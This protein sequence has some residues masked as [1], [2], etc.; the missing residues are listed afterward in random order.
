ML[1]FQYDLIGETD[2]Q[3]DRDPKKR[4]AKIISELDVNGDKK[5]NKQ[6]FITG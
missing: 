4:A 6:E 3:G 2:R 1:S 5:L